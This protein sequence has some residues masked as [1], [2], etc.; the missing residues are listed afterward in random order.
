MADW[1]SGHPRPLPQASVRLMTAAR[2]DLPQV[3]ERMLAGEW[4]ID[5]AAV[6]SKLAAAGLPAGPAV[7]DGRYVFVGPAL[8]PVGEDPPPRLRLGGV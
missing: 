4:G 2:T 6:V 3:R 1:V 5:G 8:R 7:R